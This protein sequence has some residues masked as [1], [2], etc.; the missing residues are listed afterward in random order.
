M[1][2]RDL[3]ELAPLPL[4]LPAPGEGEGVRG[5]RGAL[6]AALVLML[7]LMLV[8]MLDIAQAQA[9]TP[10]SS[11]ETA[12]TLPDIQHEMDGVG[13][14]YAYIRRHFPGWKPGR[15]ALLNHNGRHYDAIDL[16]GPDGARRTVFFD[17]TPWFGK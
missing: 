11:I 7:V 17:I 12:I 8:A 1:H 3:T 14:E 4:P 16:L 2:G 5:H 13:A 10:G 9:Q 15:Q 6:A